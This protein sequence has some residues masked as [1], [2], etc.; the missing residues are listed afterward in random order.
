M[1]RR[2]KKRRRIGRA[3]KLTVAQILAWADDHHARFG[4]WPS[5]DSGRIETGRILGGLGTTW[6]AVNSA[7]YLGL[8]GLPGGSSLARLLAEH[9]GYRNHMDLP[10]LTTATLLAWADAHRQRTGA[11]PTSTSGPIIDAPGETWGAVQCSLWVG[12]RGLPGGSSL[13]RFLAEHRGHRN[14]RGLPPLTVEQILAWADAFH[15][16][17]GKWPVESLGA[18]EGED[19]TTWTSVDI[20]LRVGL[21]GLPGGSSLARLLAEHRGYRIHTALPDLTA[22]TILAWADAHHERTGAW[23]KCASGRIIAAPGRETWQAIDAALRAGARGLPG[24]SSLPR[25]LAEQRGVRN[26][27]DLPPLTREQILAWADTYHQH[28]GR[29]PKMDTAGPIADAPGE[30]WLSVDYALRKGARGLGGESSLARLL[31]EQRGVIPRTGNPQL[32]T[33]RGVAKRTFGNPFTVEQV[34]AWAEAHRQR[35]GQWPN[36]RA[37]PIPEA[38]DI[39]WATVDLA[40]R[41]GLAGPTGWTLARLL[42]ERLHARGLG[43]DPPLRVGRIVVWA[44]SHRRCTGSWPSA[45]SGPVIGVPGETWKGINSALEQG[46]RSLPGDSS[47]A[48]LLA[49]HVGRRH[50][51]QPPPLTMDQVVAWANQHR[52]RTGRWP[53]V[54]VG[55]IE[56]APGET[57]LAVD[58]ALKNGKRGLPGGISLAQLRAE[59]PDAG[60]LLF[61]PPLTMAQVL[62]WADAHY[63]RHGRWPSTK[64]GPIRGSRGETWAAVNHALRRGCRGLPG[65]STLS[66]LLKKHRA[67]A[68]AALNLSGAQVP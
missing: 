45:R 64:S 29:W 31:A 16:R 51:K 23:P 30:T 37:G 22:A 41:R 24:G 67:L 10:K 54:N 61:R 21:R 43:Y 3:P 58:C 60:P 55:P 63:Q 34:L 18:I 48:K 50:H 32:T 12:L 46:T 68:E 5:Q 14:K 19:G 62:A 4:K 56:G 42:T 8:R 49:E 9:R 65:G 25:L 53:T 44:E 26:I 38:P 35:T 11:W 47:L 40:L 36:F 7:L 6:N 27:H 20:A 59:Q 13:A 52:E 57:W 33:E 66:K 1:K 2:K 15:A 39:A 17:S 28:T